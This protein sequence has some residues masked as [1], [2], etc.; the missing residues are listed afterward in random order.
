MQ[1]DLLQLPREQCE[2]SL[3]LITCSVPDIK[4]T[5]S[6]LLIS[7]R[8]CVGYTLAESATS[9]ILDKTRRENVTHHYKMVI[10]LFVCVIKD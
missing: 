3:F 9:T 1:A 4:I 10:P 2:S 7:K 8:L 5:L 6:V